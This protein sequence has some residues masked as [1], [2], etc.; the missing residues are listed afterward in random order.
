MGEV[1]IVVDGDDLGAVSLAAASGDTDGRYACSICASAGQHSM[2]ARTDLW[3][4]ST[5]GPSNP[6]S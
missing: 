1:V 4:D 2:R 3:S 6:T 5:G